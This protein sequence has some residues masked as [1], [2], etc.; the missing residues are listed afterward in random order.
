M[1]WKVLWMVTRFTWKLRLCFTVSSLDLKI[2][3]G[4][5]VVRNSVSGMRTLDKSIDLFL[6]YLKPL[7]QLT[8]FLNCVNL[9]S[10]QADKHIFVAWGSS[11]LGQLSVVVGRN[12]V[13]LFEHAL[14]VCILSAWA[15]GPLGSCPWSAIWVLCAWI[16]LFFAS[17]PKQFYTIW[18]NTTKFE[19][20]TAKW[21]TFLWF[22]A[23]FI[24]LH[25]W[26][27]SVSVVH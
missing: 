12:Q 23:E 6:R 5:S 21:L 11:W 20:M 8:L 7:T 2:W 16:S 9:V 14:W 25:E 17:P 15:V 18:S 22:W 1:F 26:N 27:Y 24:G 10:V 3:F 19:F 4:S 13:L